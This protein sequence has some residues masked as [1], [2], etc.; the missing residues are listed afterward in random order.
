MIQVT[1]TFKTLDA[2]LR[3]LREIPESCLAIDVTEA[4]ADPKPQE[5]K[6]KAPRAKAAPTAPVEVAAPAPTTAAPVVAPPPVAA[7][8]EPEPA[9]P[10]APA[11]EY[12]ILQRKAFEL[13]PRLG[14]A[15]I[16]AIAEKHGAGTF[17]E[18]PAE[19]W[20]AAYDDLVALED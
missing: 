18:L 13:L 8:V 1:L 5:P 6:A 16:L 14:K 11:F 9:A 17:K 12:A 15:Q 10:S 2:A 3:G 4:A 19:R 7:P 20:Q